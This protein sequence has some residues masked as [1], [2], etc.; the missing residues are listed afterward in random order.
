MMEAAQLLA[1]IPGCLK[2]SREDKQAPRRL[3]FGCIS[4]KKTSN[5]YN[6]L[7]NLLLIDKSLDAVA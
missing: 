2:I 3:Y 5:L 6:E 7:K 1:V 4:V